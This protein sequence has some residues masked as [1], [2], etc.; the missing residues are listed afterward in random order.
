MY[1]VDFYNRVRR[2][3]L[4]DGMSVRAA[5]RYFN[6]DRK[7]IVK[8]LRHELPPHC[9]AGHVYMPEKGVSSLRTVTSSNP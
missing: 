7:T 3:C 2:A 1:S 6:K 5:A 4:R 8:M 9:L